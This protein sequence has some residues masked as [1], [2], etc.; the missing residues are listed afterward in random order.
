MAKP[1]GPEWRSLTWSLEPDHA[2][3]GG[4]DDRVVVRLL[5]P[6]IGASSLALVFEAR[7]AVT[8][9]GVY[10]EADDAFGSSASVA[11][12]APIGRLIEDASVSAE[13]YFQQKG[14]TSAESSLAEKL[15][16]AR[17]AERLAR[18]GVVDADRAALAILDLFKTASIAASSRAW[19]V[20]WIAS[21]LGLDRKTIQRF[22][23]RGRELNEEGPT[24]QEVYA[25]YLLGEG[26]VPT[27]EQADA[28]IL[29]DQVEKLTGSVFVPLDQIPEREG[30]EDAT[31][32]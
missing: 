1:V 30:G 4:V 19:P 6:R 2:L 9:V 17:E 31:T 22:I 26:G 18:K 24:P 12:R 13:A 8:C 28:I 29:M 32:P 3:V 25:D 20:G 23:A 5:R 11:L 16:L 21:Q 14:T 10:F 7:S 15:E 27:P